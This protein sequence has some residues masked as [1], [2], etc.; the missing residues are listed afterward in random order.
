MAVYPKHFD[1]FLKQIISG[2][3]RNLVKS[4]GIVSHFAR[5]FHLEFDF[6]VMHY[7]TLVGFFFFSLPEDLRTEQSH[8][9]WGR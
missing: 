5:F 9:L 8:F 3:A 7:F 6:W 4:F 2:P 1:I